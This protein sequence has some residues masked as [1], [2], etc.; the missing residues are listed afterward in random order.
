MTHG[1]PPR[2]L[3]TRSEPGA[4]ETALR[5]GQSGFDPVVEALFAIAPV[6]VTLPEFDALAF[7]SANGVRRFARL[8]P[9]R[10][11]P[12]FCVGERTAR[13]ARDAG[14]LHVSSS[15]ATVDALATLIQR[16]LA[17]GARLLHAGNEET[18]GDLAGR[19]SAAGRSAAFLPIFRA[20]PVE[21]PGPVLAAHLAGEAS[22][23]A[24]LIHSPRAASILTGFVSGMTSAGH[25]S[26]AAISQAAAEPLE[27][28]AERLEIATSPDESALISALS[29]LVFG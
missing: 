7:T 20:V 11:T 5:L 10:D 1:A 2:V 23:D 26:V 27:G 13:E 28:F 24:I 15:N 18:R 9:R 8:S 16:E 4:T 25:L 21:A 29:R 12:V 19:L 22:L 6:D 3:V 17:P 14:Y